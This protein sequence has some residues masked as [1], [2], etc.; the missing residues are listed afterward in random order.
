MT[1]GDGEA[2]LG[3]FFVTVHGGASGAVGA[4]S[5]A[6][7]DAGGEFGLGMICCVKAR[8]LRWCDKMKR[9]F[10]PLVRVIFDF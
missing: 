3:F 1:L 10:I 4:I 5:S 2:S 6:G 9:I 7:V 8:R